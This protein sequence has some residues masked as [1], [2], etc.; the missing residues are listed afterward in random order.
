MSGVGTLMTSNAGC[1]Q[2]SSRLEFLTGSQQVTPH[3]FY[4]SSGAFISGLWTTESA[5]FNMR[6]GF[7]N[8]RGVRGTIRR[9]T[10]F[11]A[12][13]TLEYSFLFSMIIFFEGYSL[14][15]IRHRSLYAY[16]YLF[17]ALNADSNEFIYSYD[18]YTYAIAVIHFL[19]FSLY[20][21]MSTIGYI[22]VI[23]IYIT[24]IPAPPRV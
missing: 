17:Y 23:Q 2:Q 5:D 18:G 14:L 10:A 12:A 8:M 16:I 1:R 7:A 11:T 21:Y 22:R 3:L 4:H 24:I 19:S 20:I 9:M 13:A 6:I 15:A